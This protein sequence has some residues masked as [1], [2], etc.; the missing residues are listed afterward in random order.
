LKLTI[1]SNR[2]YRE[3]KREGIRDWDW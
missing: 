1:C 3:R 2:R